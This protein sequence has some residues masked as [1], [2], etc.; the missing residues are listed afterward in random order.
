VA[1]ENVTLTKNPSILVWRGFIPTGFPILH[2]RF[3]RPV[4][5]HFTR[6]PV[7]LTPCVSLTSDYPQGDSNPCLSRERDR[8]VQKTLVFCGNS[9]TILPATG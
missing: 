4:T 1:D 9:V 5:S 3:T 2:F 7:V 8:M 6:H